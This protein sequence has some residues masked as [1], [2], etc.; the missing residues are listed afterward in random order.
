MVNTLVLYDT[1]RKTTRR[2][3]EV[4]LRAHGFVWLFPHARWSARPLT[5]H[6]GLARRVRSRMA[7]ESYRLVLLEIPARSRLAARW[8]SAAP[9]ER[10]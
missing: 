5:A 6:H 8:L 9:S 1:P 2:R 4:L 7:G 10:L 3:L